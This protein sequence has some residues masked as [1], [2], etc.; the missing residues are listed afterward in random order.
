V[1][2]SDS[3]A[4]VAVSFARA[5][6]VPQLVDPNPS[7]EILFYIFDNH[8]A[9]VRFKGKRV[10][11]SGA[12]RVNTGYLTLNEPF[13]LPKGKYTAK[14]LLRISGTRSMGFVRRDFAV[15]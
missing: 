12:G 15:E 6:V 10:N 13:D 5:E 9:A 3:G 2:T 7:V 8:G 4:E 1:R 11:F 14:V